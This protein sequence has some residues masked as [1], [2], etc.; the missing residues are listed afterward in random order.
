VLV[1]NEEEEMISAKAD[2]HSSAQVWGFPI[3][4]SIDCRGGNGK[5]KK[6]GKN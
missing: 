1:S 2:T 4:L 6:Y 3:G 5:D